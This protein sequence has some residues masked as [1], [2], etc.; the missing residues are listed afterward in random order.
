MSYA[1]ITADL[2]MGLEPHHGEYFS[3]IK[4]KIYSG[5]CHCSDLDAF[6][7]HF[8][9]VA[10]LSI[11]MTSKMFIY[12]YEY[13]GYKRSRRLWIL[14]MSFVLDEIDKTLDKK[15]DCK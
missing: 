7:F 8:L 9:I 2:D 14:S 11:T 3:G 5:T 12:L 15:G 13:I 10:K 4:N 1:H 6:R